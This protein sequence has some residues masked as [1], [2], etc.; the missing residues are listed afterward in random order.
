MTP[1]QMKLMKT[2]DLKYV[3]MKR[4]AEAKVIHFIFSVFPSLPRIVL[5]T[6]KKK[7]KRVVVYTVSTF[8]DT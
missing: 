2:Q 8:S 4:V 5:F 6:L 3:E 7:K 1:E